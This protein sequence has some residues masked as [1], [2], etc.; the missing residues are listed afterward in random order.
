MLGLKLERISLGLTGEEK[1]ER[2]Q[3]RVKLG[4]MQAQLALA[5]AGFAAGFAAG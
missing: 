5:A 1:W 4:S 2:L 3:W